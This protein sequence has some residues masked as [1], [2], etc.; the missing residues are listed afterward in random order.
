MLLAGYV[1]LLFRRA[2]QFMNVSNFVPREYTQ[3]KEKELGRH[4][5][6]SENKNRMKNGASI[7]TAKR[8]YSSSFSHQLPQ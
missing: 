6:H 4:I 2:F 5:L 1:A 7:N 8:L 3:K